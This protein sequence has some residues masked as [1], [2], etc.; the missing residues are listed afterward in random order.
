MDS[1]IMI[2]VIPMPVES[3]GNPRLM[4]LDRMIMFVSFDLAVFCFM[5]I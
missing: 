1:A 2:P 4:N 3:H 5:I